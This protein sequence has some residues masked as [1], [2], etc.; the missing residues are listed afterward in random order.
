MILV[1]VFHFETEIGRRGNE[2]GGDGR[3]KW[4]GGSYQNRGY[5]KR[6]SCWNIYYSVGT[7]S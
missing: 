5:K 7:T 2:N 1:K 3:L 4:G 6:L